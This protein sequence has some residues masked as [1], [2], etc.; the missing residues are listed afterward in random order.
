M[1]DLRYIEETSQLDIDTT[2]VKGEIFLKFDPLFSNNSTLVLISNLNLG[3]FFC[4]VSKFSKPSLD[5]FIDNLSLVVELID[6]TLRARPLFSAAVR[7]AAS[8][9]V[10][11]V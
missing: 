1:S 2:I 8:Y 10:F 5:H 4:V 3:D 6:A 7:K 9:R 11:E